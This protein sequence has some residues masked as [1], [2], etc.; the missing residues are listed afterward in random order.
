MK[1]LVIDGNSIINRAFYGIKLLNAKDGHFTN[2]IYGFMNILLNLDE[3]YS[4]DGIIV[5]FD[6]HAPTFRHEMYDGYKAGRKSPPP[7]LLEQFEPLKTLL[8]AYGCHIIECP[9]FEADDILGT[10]SVS[11]TADD[12]C[13]IA[14]GDRDSLQLIRNNV[15]VL[16]TTTKMGK[17]QTVEYD[18][19]RLF[20]E[21]GVSP[22][23]MIELKALQGDSSDNIPG[24]AGIGPKTAGDLIKKYGNID[25]IYEDIDTIEASAGVKAKLISGKDSAF[26]SR[27]LGTINLSA[28]INTDMTKYLENVRDSKLM[29]SELARHEMFKLITRLK[30]DIEKSNALRSEFSDNNKNINLKFYV[31]DTN[32]AAQLL[33]DKDKIYITVNFENNFPLYVS[34]STETEVIIVENS[35]LEFNTFFKSV[36]ESEKKIITEDCKNLYSYCLLQ[37]IDPKNIIFDVKLAAYLLDVNSSDYS[38]QSLSLSYN[39]KSLTAVSEDSDTESFIAENKDFCET[40]ALMKVLADRLSSIISEREQELLLRD[41]EIPLAKVLSSMEQIGMK[42]DVNGIKEFSDV[43]SANIHNIETS[44]YELAGEKFNINSPKQLGV[45]LF[46]KLG[47]PAKK[48]TKTGYSTNAEVL[49]ALAEEYPIVSLILEYRTYAKLKSTYCEGLLKAVEADNRVRCTFNQTETR[50]GRLS[51]T[52]PNLQNIPVRTALGREMRKFFIADDGYAIIDADYSQIELRVLAAL[53]GDKN[54]IDAFN[55]GTDIHSVTAS[56]VFG[57]P[58]NVVT[59]ELRSKA[60]AVNFGIVYGIGAFSLSKDIKTTRAEADSFIK[61]YLALYSSVSD[62][63]DKCIADAKEKG[64]S[65]TLFKR[66]RYLPELTSSNGMLRSFG[67][68]VARNMPIQGTA[69]DII[70]IAMIKVYERLKSEYPDTKLIMQVHDE[71]MAEAPEKD[72]AAVADL[73]KEEMEN[74]VNLVVKFA[75]DTAIGRSWYDAKE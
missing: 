63:M 5:A 27:K 4:P 17:T 46:E 19:N 54:M 49:E 42:V 15:S 22:S 71:L 53:S 51:S 34:F 1:Y 6:V 31:V 7:E 18:E 43:L 61:S 69:A 40:A 29:L 8:R 62:Y 65:E 50:T 24:V 73:I 55:S 32:K 30:L 52:E 58:L 72:A 33:E 13:Y 67:E 28:P 64:Y 10:L 75:A 45:I 3:K 9:G 14:T 2:A 66:R 25:T 35:N 37:N 44:I 48:K 16:L 36:L 11:I 26:F 70:K 20:E 68:R 21:Y 60:K 47:L 57:V 56:K 23:G 41:I 74:A 38:V 39:V 12:H 59:G